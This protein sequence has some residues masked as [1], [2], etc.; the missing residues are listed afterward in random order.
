MNE[1][2]A[3]H[4]CYRS[5]DAF[6]TRSLKQGARPIASDSVVSPC[7]GV[8]SSMGIIDEGAR[9]FVKGSPYEVGELLGAS[10]LARDYIGGQFMV[11]YLSPRDYHRVHSPIDGGLRGVIAMP[12]DCYPVNSLGERCEPQLYVRN[13]RVTYLMELSDQS[14]MALVMVSAF[15]VGRITVNALGGHRL[16]EGHHGFDSTVPM[17][18]GDEIGSFHLGSTVVLLSNAKVQLAAKEGKVRC[19]ESL[20]RSAG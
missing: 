4:G 3:P 18:R 19:G 14:P 5:F 17:K 2:A 1:A 7:D 9:M 10:H 15:I 6:F 11:I 20:T 16:S 13:R 8:V 12:G